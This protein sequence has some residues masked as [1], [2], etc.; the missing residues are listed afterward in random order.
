MPMLLRNFMAFLVPVISLA[1]SGCG[2]DPLENV[3]ANCSIRCDKS[4]QCD[5]GATSKDTCMAICRDQAKD[6]AY[7]EAIDL[8]SECYSSSTCDQILG[9]GCDPQDL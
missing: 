9:G 8:Q 7:A 4:V 2:S 6:E 1:T 3:E 5:T